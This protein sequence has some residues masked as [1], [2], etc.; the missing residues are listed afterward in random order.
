MNKDKGFWRGLENWD[1]VILIETWV[2]KKDWE[3]IRDKL[4]G[5]YEWELQDAKRISK[6]GRA[7]GGM[8]MGIRKGLKIKK[9]EMGSNMEGLMIRR[10]KY[11]K[12]S[13]RIVG[14]YVNR[15]MEKKLEG[16]R[17]WMEK[18]EKGVRTIFGGDFNARTGEEGRR[19]RGERRIIKEIE[20]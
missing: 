16:M 9:R 19:R 2:E 14:V 11:G 10:V 8:I 12:G 5:E 4:S 18:K 6:R 13:L 20:R 17:K 15:D 7:I 3:K 1:V